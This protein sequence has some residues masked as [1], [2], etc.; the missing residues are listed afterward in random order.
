MHLLISLYLSHMNSLKIK[1]LFITELE[2]QNSLLDQ[3]QTSQW[4]W[5]WPSKLDSDSLYGLVHGFLLGIQF[6]INLSFEFTW[7][8]WTL[9]CHDSRVLH[10][11][12][13]LLVAWNLGFR[14]AIS[15]L[16]WSHLE[17]TLQAGLVMSNSFEFSS[18]QDVPLLM[19][20]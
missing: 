12:L 6:D 2:K 20:F 7:S 4:D 11:R 10:D 16:I 17:S 9:F 14:I 13:R 18:V 8:R 1:T 19:Y 5:Y 15:E 3:E